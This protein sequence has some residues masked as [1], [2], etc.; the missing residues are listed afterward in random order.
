MQCAQVHTNDLRKKNAENSG[1][2]C[3]SKLNNSAGEKCKY[4][5]TT[6]GKECR[7]TVGEIRRWKM[8]YNFLY[9]NHNSE[10]IVHNHAS[11]LPLIVS[12]VTLHSL[13]HSKFL[14]TYMKLH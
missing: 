6:G 8:R 11:P 13:L 1:G 5:Q 4:I 2:V 12:V 14:G 9:T 10:Q 3:R 7:K